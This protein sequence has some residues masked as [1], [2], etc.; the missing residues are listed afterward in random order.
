MD[1]NAGKLLGVKRLGECSLGSKLRVTVDRKEGSSLAIDS[2]MFDRLH[3][4]GY[5]YT[6]LAAVGKVS[7]RQFDGK[8]ISQD[9]ALNFLFQGMFALGR[10]T[11][12]AVY[13][14]YA[15]VG[16]ADLHAMNIDKRE[17]SNL[18]FTTQ[19]NFT[20]VK[21]GDILGNI[22]VNDIV[23]EGEDGEHDIG[24]IRLQSRT[25]GG[26]HRISLDS[27]LLRGSYIGTEDVGRFA[28]DLVGL[29]LKREL[30][31]LFED[32]GFE[33]GGAQYDLDLQCVN[34]SELAT[35]LNPDLYVDDNT[36][37]GL[38]VYRNGVI[39][40]RVKTHRIALKDRYIKDLDCT[41]DNIEERLRA[42]VVCGSVSLG[43]YSFDNGDVKVF[44]D[45]NDVRLGLSYDNEG[46]VENRGDL[47]ALGRLRRDE[48][49]EVAVR[50]EI[51]PSAIVFENNS[52]NIMESSFEVS[53]FRLKV[54]SL[55]VSNGE[56]VLRA[57]GGVSR[58]S[59][60]SLDLSIQR[61]NIGFINNLLKG[62]RMDVGGVLSGNVSLRSSGGRLGY[63]AD[64]VCDST[65]VSKTSLGTVV[66]RSKYDREFSR[67]DIDVRSVREDREALCLLGTYTPASKYVD[68]SMDIDNLDIGFAT[69]FLPEVFSRT[70]GKVTGKVYAEGNIGS[71][72]LYS[73]GLK[74][75]DTELEVAFTHVPYKVNGPVT[76]D[77]Y[78]VYFDNVK[79][80]DR[81]DAPGVVNGE[82]YYDHFKDI[83]LDLHIDTDKMELIDIP[84]S[85]GR[86]FYGNVFGTGRV[87]I[88]GP[89]R[90]L[91]IDV[92]ENTVGT[93]KGDFHIPLSNSGENKFSNLLV[94]K[95]PKTDAV[96][97]RY[98][99]LL[100]M[101]RDRKKKKSRGELSVHI[102]AN[103]TPDVSAHLELNK[104]TGNGLTGRGS[105]LIEMDVM[106]SKS[107]INYKGDYTLESGDYKFIIPNLVTK[108]F[109][110][111]NGSSI[112]F[113]GDLP[114][115]TLSIDAVYKTKASIATLISDTTSVNTRRAIECGINISDK[116]SN[117]QIK[118]SLDIPDLDPT[119]K[120]KVENAL[121]TE[122]K[123][124]RQF[125]ALLITNNFLPDDAS[126]ITTNTAGILY[127]NVSEVMSR[128]I[129]KIFERLDIPLDLGVKYQTNARGND[130]FDVALSTQLFNNRVIVGGN[131]GNRQYNS[132][133]SDIAGDL[134]IEVKIDRPGALRLNAFSH[135]S[136]Q[137]TNYLDNLQRN[138]I[139]ITYQKEFNSLG[140]LMKY[141]FSSRA[142][143]D[144][145][146][147]EEQRRKDADG[148]KTITIDANE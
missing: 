96:E 58:D 113:G 117:P 64:V 28:S 122:D 10:K 134:D 112:Q 51:V 21:T 50:T 148:Y 108:E 142:K 91:D 74:L 104:D 23:L 71:Y 88:T 15:N 123:L 107:Y 136:D 54:D 18:S 139:G 133:G 56:Q 12:N 114:E 41:I 105:G 46:V 121:S 137:Y 57:R 6:R 140:Y 68:L 82:I 84:E 132:N 147:I 11:S 73:E 103:A 110:I 35:F 5:D 101:Y 43:E 3:F 27:E 42:D 79:V 31:V 125:L 1:F 93:G 67:Y 86:G 145:M 70:G 30:P 92:D 26:L 120:S 98:E 109:S 135:H 38:S 118:F 131:L 16:H 36:S 143:K 34:T 127:S 119:V 39:D 72:R 29:T 63:V 146:E 99:E 20:K 49:G 75:V 115:S 76:M 126:G 141:M 66:V 60:D 55:Q 7:S 83:G 87:N 95:Q 100:R 85:A 52:W 61:F 90:S 106:P 9:P 77:E 14:F 25:G 4:N 37:I 22:N 65:V 45:D 97:D 24:D 47:Y 32:S 19:A 128:Q 80:R 138:G 124:Q 62:S 59:A 130:I 8:I 78:G 81:Y 33:W 17:T 102:R 94:F 129:N 69:P 116:L 2:L 111:R 13:Q 44:A 40:A 48:R 89:V 144:S 53:K